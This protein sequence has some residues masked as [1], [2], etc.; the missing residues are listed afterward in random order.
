MNNSQNNSV[1]KYSYTKKLTYCAMCIAL[2]TAL[3]YI[4]LFKAPMGGSVTLCSMLFIVLAGYKFGTR[5]GIITGAAYGLLQFVLEPYFYTLPQ[6]ILDYP[7]AFGA[8]GLAG[9]FRNHK[10][11]LQLGYITAVLG[12]MLC[13]TLSGV[14]FFAQYAPEGMN[15]LVY[16]LSYNGSYLGAEAVITLIIISMPPLKKVLINFKQR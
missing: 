11:G 2:A 6:V 7:L 12:R 9:I 16:S 8:L 14:I 15:P 10:H 4:K 5:A 13:A 3:S 1:N